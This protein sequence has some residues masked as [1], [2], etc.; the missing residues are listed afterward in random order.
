MLKKN[1]FHNIDDT[2]YNKITGASAI[3]VSFT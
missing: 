2:F 1:V 3:G